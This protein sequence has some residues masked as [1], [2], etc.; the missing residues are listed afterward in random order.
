MTGDREY[1]LE[2]LIEYNEL[3][4]TLPPE[5]QKEMT[6]RMETVKTMFSAAKASTSSPSQQQQ[7]YNMIAKTLEEMLNDMRGYIPRK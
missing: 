6:G 1:F 7:Y 2:K 3:F 4:V 5:T